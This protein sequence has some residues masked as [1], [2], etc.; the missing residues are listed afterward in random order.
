MRF[1][2]VHLLLFFLAFAIAYSLASNFTPQPPDQE[3]DH[4]LAERQIQTI[5]FLAVNQVERDNPFISDLKPKFTDVDQRRLWIEAGN[6]T[7]PWG[8]SF[9]IVDLNREGNFKEEF[10]FHVFSCGVDGKSNS[11][12]NDEDDINTWDYNR[13]QYYAKLVAPIEA[14]LLKQHRLGVIFRIL[15]FTPIIFVAI[16]FLMWTRKGTADLKRVNHGTGRRRVCAMRPIW[17]LRVA[18]L[19]PPWSAIR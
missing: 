14:E 10:S 2:I 11:E 12:G 5:R 18:S 19:R 16:L 15:I 8:N 6:T 17:P 9:Q 1:S 3:Y 13:D 4:D 7:D